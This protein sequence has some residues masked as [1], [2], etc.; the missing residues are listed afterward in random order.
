MDLREERRTRRAAWSGLLIGL[1]VAVGLGVLVGYGYLAS[2]PEAVPPPVRDNR[3]VQDAISEGCHL[4]TAS[5]GGA[6]ADLLARAEPGA[7]VRGTLPNDTRLDV[8]S[9]RR[10]YVE[11]RVRGDV[12]WIDRRDVREVCP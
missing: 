1:A 11:A 9:V 4:V 3:V 7:M 2:Q 10:D 6:E 8:V 12:V 5:R